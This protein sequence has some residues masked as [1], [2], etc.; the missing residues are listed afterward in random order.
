[1]G[2]ETRLNWICDWSV[3]VYVELERQILL[4]CQRDGHGPEYAQNKISKQMSGDEKRKRAH[5]VLENSG[6]VDMLKDKVED[7][8]AELVRDEKGGEISWNAALAPT[9]ISFFLGGLGTAIAIFLL[10]TVVVYF[11][12]S[13]SFSFSNNRLVLI[14]NKI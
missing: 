1:M 12:V 6:T 14:Q 13:G 2:F 10:S 11:F 7:F 5:R 4:L 3:T 9:K 8:V